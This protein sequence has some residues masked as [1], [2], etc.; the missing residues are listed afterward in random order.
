MAQR[1]TYEL[2]YVGPSHLQ[3][4]KLAEARG[5]R[6]DAR[7]QYVSFIDSWRTADP[8]LM[9]LVDDARQRLAKLGG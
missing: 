4:A 7:R 3:L 1:A 9:P 5:D 2:P 6:D 8:E